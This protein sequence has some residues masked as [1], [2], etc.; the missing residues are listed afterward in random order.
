MKGRAL[1]WIRFFSVLVFVLFLWVGAA[2]AA[3][4]INEWAASAGATGYKIY[5]SEDLGVTW[6]A[7][8]DVGNVVSYTW[9]GVVDTRL[10]LFRVSAY[11][12]SGET[13]RYWSGTFW[14][15][16]WKPVSAASSLGIR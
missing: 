16:L 10:V 1:K 4:V 3:D 13:V 15:S 6:S 7:P 8:V 9:V 11:N 14:N 5:K 2:F 12:A